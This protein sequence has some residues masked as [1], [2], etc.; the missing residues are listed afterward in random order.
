MTN[1]T[2]LA[3]WRSSHPRR[4]VAPVQ[5]DPLI[6]AVEVM[7]LCWWMPM[8]AFSMQISAPTREPRQ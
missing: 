7:A 8:I 6:L 2:N 3:D 5:A 1:V 4:P